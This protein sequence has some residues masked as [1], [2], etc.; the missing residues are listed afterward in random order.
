MEKLY[1]S[2]EIY[3][4]RL[5]KN[6][7]VIL[8]PY[9]YNPITVVSYDI[10]QILQYCKKGKTKQEIKKKF[11]TLKLE[12]IT[13]TIKEL[14]EIGLLNTT[15]SFKQSFGERLDRID[16]WIH[17]TNECNLACR[18]CYVIKDDQKMSKVTAD[19]IIQVLVN[20]VDKEKLHS[21]KIKFSGGEALLNFDI[22]KYFH[23]ELSNALSNKKIKKE[24]VILT[25]GTIMTDKIANWLLRNKIRLAISLDGSKK[26]HDKQRQFSNGRGSYDLIMR[27]LTSIIKAKIPYNLSI[28]LTDE[29][30]KGLAQTLEWVM[31]NDIAFSLNFYRENPCSSGD[32]K[33][34]VS[35]KKFVKYLT[36]AFVVIEKNLSEK[37]LI[38]VLG[39][40]I[41]FATTHQKTC[42]VGRSYVVFDHKGFVSKCQMDMANPVGD[43]D[44]LIVSK[45]SVLKTIKN[46]SVGIINLP[47]EKKGECAK[48]FWR[49]YCCG[50]CPYECFLVKGHYNAKSPKCDLYKQIMPMIVRLEG[51]RLLKFKG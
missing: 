30:V 38:N 14:I 49:Y 11:S 21:I 7:Y 19:K 37:S 10:L 45:E 29:N 23:Q 13:K 44:S 22:I 35:T 9:V 1:S 36:E 16:C 6:S 2:K 20:T 5:K 31:K 43:V 41:I 40:R 25:N 3:K 28:T 33:L 17:I 8:S 24:F 39:D 15:G 42:S 46:N 32:K 50:G 34:E 48:C 27:N 12:Y 18:Y 26:Y 51:L 47:V 4:E